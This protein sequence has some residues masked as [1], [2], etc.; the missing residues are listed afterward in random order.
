MAENQI[1]NKQF[2]DTTKKER[3]AQGQVAHLSKN[4]HNFDQSSLI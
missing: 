2:I 4:G 3:D 1:V